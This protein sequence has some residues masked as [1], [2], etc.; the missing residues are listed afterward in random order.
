M[1]AIRQ[2]KIAASDNGMFSRFG[3]SVSI[4]GDGNTIAVGV[5]F[6]DK[7]SNA[8][9]GSTYIYWRS[10]GQWFQQEKVTSTDGAAFDRFGWS[11]S[12]SSD[13]NTMVVGAPYN[14]ISGKSEQG[15]AYVFVRIKEQWIQQQKLTALDGSADDHFGQSVLINGSGNLVVSGAPEKNIDRNASQGSVYVLFKGLI[16]QFTTIAWSGILVIVFTGFSLLYYLR[17]RGK[18]KS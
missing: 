13:G 9:Q 10:G 12:I 15:S 7:G 14:K 11:V 16:P 18:G 1:G 8:D 5:P 3:W 17:R 2:Q 6:D 4:S